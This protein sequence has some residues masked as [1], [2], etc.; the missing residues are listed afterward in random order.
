MSLP[1]PD[2]HIVNACD[3]NVC[4]TQMRTNIPGHQRQENKY[5]NKQTNKQTTEHQNNQPTNLSTNE[6]FNQPSKKQASKQARID[7]PVT[8]PNNQAGHKNNQYI[9]NLDT[10]NYIIHFKYNLNKP[11]YAVIVVLGTI[12]ISRAFLIKI[13]QKH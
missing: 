5:K 2:T 3:T 9:L 8:Q 12:T 13:C 6:A 7:Q 10:R 1:G 4:A 11:K